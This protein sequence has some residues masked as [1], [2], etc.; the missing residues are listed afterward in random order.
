M[1]AIAIYPGSFDPL[2]NGHL[3]LIERG[4]RLFGHLIVAVARN[5]EKT[6]LFTTQERIELVREAVNRRADVTVESFEGLLVDYARVR[7]A[8]VVMRGLRALSDFEYEYEMAM[9]NR[10][11]HPELETLFMMTSESNFFVSSR[12]VKEVMRFGGDVSS[13]VP[14]LV[15]ARL[16][17][18]LG[19]AP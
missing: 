10:R 3:D 19:R 5:I 17:E 14:P 9:M 4:V 2:T 13:L 15:Q 16:A 11:L 12:R 7:G 6:T 1:N 18:K 8:T